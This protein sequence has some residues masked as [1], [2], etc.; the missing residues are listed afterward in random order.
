MRKRKRHRKATRRAAY[1]RR[2]RRSR[3]NPLV[4]GDK[5]TPAARAEVLRAFIYRWTKDN[6]RRESVRRGIS[7]KP[8]IPLISDAQ[9]LRE[10]AFMVTKS[11]ELSRSHRYAEPHYM[12]ANPHRKNR[13]RRYA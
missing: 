12:T 2:A 10:H 5:L 11:G 8:T 7:G 4:R 3:S 1:N 13:R 9:W 6:E